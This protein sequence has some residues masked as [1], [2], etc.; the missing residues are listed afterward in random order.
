M[1]QVTISIDDALYD[2]TAKAAGAQGKSIDEL[3][4]GLLEREVGPMRGNGETEDAYHARMELVAMARRT[5]IPRRLT[6]WTREE[7]YDRG[8]SG[9]ERDR[10]RRLGPD[11][12]P[13]EMGESGGDHAE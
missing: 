9:Y 1:K 3:M 10:V 5:D 11:G 13:A 7:L 6:P 8:V 4:R 2:R 12:G